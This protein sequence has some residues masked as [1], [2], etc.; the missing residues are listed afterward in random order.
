[1]SREPEASGG[2]SDPAADRRRFV[3]GV[4]LMC[5]SMFLLACMDAGTKIL[6][7]DLA[8]PFIVWVRFM[9][10]SAVGMVLVRGRVLPTLRASRW[11]KMQV[12][13]GLLLTCEI[14]TFALA[15][16]YM[17]LADTH[18]IGASTP[19]MA[20]ALSVPLLAEKVGPRRWFAVIA[21]FIGV[22]IIIR[23]GMGVMSA[24][25]F[26]PLVG[27]VLFAL[28]QVMTRMVNRDDHPETTMLFTAVVGLVAMTVVGPF[29]YRPISLENA[30]F[31][32]L[33]GLLGS[34]GHFILIKALQIAAASALQPF[35]YTILLWATVVGWI[36]F[37]HL[38]DGWTLTGA[39]I[40][41]GS[42]LY[43]L[44]RERRVKGL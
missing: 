44:F 8:V 4:L 22:L 3:K 42:G 16:H 43:A 41:V 23:P 1:M 24:A 18:A 19:L 2:G 34:A 9:F 11:K 25:A 37:G 7:D 14:G 40:V 21:G 5:L 36:V 38:P 15:V 13:R 27:S 30:G 32:L 33:V 39:A 12:F 29:F 20:T 26:I 10:F 17:P 35:H 6:T 28:Y 31:L